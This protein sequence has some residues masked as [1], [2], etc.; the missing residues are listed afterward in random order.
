M[1][2]ALG[3]SC[4]E[5]L[6]TLVHDVITNSMDQPVIKMSSETERAMKDLREFMFENVYLNPNAKGEEDKAVHMIEQ[7]FEYYAE[8]QKSFPGFLRRLWKI[9]MMRKNRSSVITLPE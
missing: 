7:L 5:R 6:N 2:Q 9:R 4:K 1:R 8:Q 3:S